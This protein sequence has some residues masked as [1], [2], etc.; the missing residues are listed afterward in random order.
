MA[1]VTG[2]SLG[3]VAMLLGLSATQSFLFGGGVAVALVPEGMLPTVTLSLA[4]G[5]QIM[6]EHKALVRRLDAVE[7]LGATTFICTDKTGTLTQNRMNVVDV[8]TAAG[9]VQ[10]TGNGY[11]PVGEL[12]GPADAKALVAPAAAA[13]LACVRGRVVRLDTWVADG[14][15]MEAAIHCLAIRAGTGT[16]SKACA[17]RPYSADRM[18]SSALRDGEVSV[19]GA[20]EAVLARCE[21]VPVEVRARLTS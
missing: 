21:S 7:T 6:A 13:A 12:T 1:T 20:P 15:P 11:E 18:L 17:K 5:A 2:L 16:T 8:V 19:L 3:G 9:S 4:R 10:V 14:D